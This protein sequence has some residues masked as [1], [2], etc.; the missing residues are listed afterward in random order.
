MDYLYLATYIFLILFNFGL[1]LRAYLDNDMKLRY[2]LNLLLSIIML[3]GL[4][5]ILYIF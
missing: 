1:Y 5:R 4:I 3:I 2:K